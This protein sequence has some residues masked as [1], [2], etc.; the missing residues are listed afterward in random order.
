MKIRKW[1]L[2]MLTFCLLIT[3]TA[4][5]KD[6]KAGGDKESPDRNA[7]G[8]VSTDTASKPEQVSNF[9]TSLI[10]KTFAS[11]DYEYTVQQDGTVYSLLHT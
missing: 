9:D 5:G 10:G 7:Y 3:A 2:L 8:N 11:G 1:I 4:C 6:K